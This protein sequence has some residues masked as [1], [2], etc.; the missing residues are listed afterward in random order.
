MLTFKEFLQLP[1]GERRRRYTELSSHDKFLVRAG[2]EISY[3]D[4]D[5]EPLTKEQLEE[6]LRIMLGENGKDSVSSEE[7]QSS[8]E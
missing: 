2:G 1:E 4:P 5:T 6:G 7:G 3:F 8:K